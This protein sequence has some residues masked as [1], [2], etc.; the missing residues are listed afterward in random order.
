MQSLSDLTM[1]ATDE[2]CVNSSET[3]CFM[4]WKEKNTSSQQ[5]QRKNDGHEGTQIAFTL[6][7]CKYKPTQRCVL[8]GQLIRLSPFNM[9]RFSKVRKFTCRVLDFSIHFVNHHFTSCRFVRLATYE[10]RVSLF[11]FNLLSNAR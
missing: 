3:A 4:T 1:I 9:L 11:A 8:R 2:E 6:L 10:R 5:S 7:Y